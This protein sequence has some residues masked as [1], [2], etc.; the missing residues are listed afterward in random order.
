MNKYELIAVLGSLASMFITIF[1]GIAV[2]LKSE[3]PEPYLKRVAKKY[4]IRPL[5][6]R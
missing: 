2:A 5:D 3:Q 1:A 4:S 6:L